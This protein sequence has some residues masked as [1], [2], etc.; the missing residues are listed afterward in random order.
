MLKA[1]WK[2]D[3]IRRDM[4]YKAYN[5]HLTNNKQIQGINEAT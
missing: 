4:V 2:R 5:A 3:I 1:R